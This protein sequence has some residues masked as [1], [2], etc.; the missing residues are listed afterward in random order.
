LKGSDNFAVIVPDVWRRWRLVL[1]LIGIRE[2]NP[3]LF[4][5]DEESEWWSKT[6]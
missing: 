3:I 5:F 4:Y 1:L 2:T 6:E